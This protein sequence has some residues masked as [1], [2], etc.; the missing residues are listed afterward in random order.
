MACRPR[1]AQMLCTCRNLGCCRGS[2]SCLW[3]SP[4]CV[5]VG[6]LARG[7]LAGAPGAGTGRLGSRARHVCRR[8]GCACVGIRGGVGRAS[9]SGLL[10]LR[11]PADGAAPRARLTAARAAPVGAL[12]GPRLRRPRN[13][14]SDRRAHVRRVELERP[15]GPGPSRFLPGPA[16]RSRGQ[17]RRHGGRPSCGNC[18][19]QAQAARKRTDPRGRRCCRCWNRSFRLGSGESGCF[20]GNCSTSSLRRIYSC[21]A[22]KALTNRYGQRSY[23]A[24]ID[25][26]APGGSLG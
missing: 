21:V 18:H 8:L 1:L 22:P 11:R 6:G 24:D 16:R 14:S 2:S 5:A 4:A 7:S 12:A 20:C 3:R 19:D 26:G 25:P 9:L 23:R 17:Y 10:P 13:R 15:G